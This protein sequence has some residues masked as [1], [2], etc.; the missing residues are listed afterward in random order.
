LDKTM[1]MPVFSMIGSALTAAWT[2]YFW[3]VRVK[4]ER[5][6]LRPHLADHEVFLGN[7]VGEARQVGIKLG[8]V[9]ANYSSLPNALLGVRL[10]IRKRDG[11]WLPI[12]SVTFDAKTPLP[13]NV[14]AMQ[15]VLVRIMGRVAFPTADDIEGTPTTLADYLNR[16]AAT[17]REIGVELRGLGDHIATAEVIMN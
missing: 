13:F 5:P 7:T 16:H 6:D 9:V 3:V 17:P 14:P 4:R 10:W 1:A 12:E 2:A 15:T 11:G 8:L